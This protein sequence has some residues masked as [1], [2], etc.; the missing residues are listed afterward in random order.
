MEDSLEKEDEEQEEEEGNTLNLH[1]TS[2]GLEL[3]VL[4]FVLSR[5][6]ISLINQY[7]LD[8]HSIKTP[9][10]H[11]STNV[12]TAVVFPKSYEETTTLLA[13]A[14]S[15]VS[16]VPSAYSIQ[17]PSTPSTQKPQV[18]KPEPLAPN[19][20]FYT[21]CPGRTLSTLLTPVCKDPQKIPA[22]RFAETP[23]VC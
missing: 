15:P 13:L 22:F 3:F 9:S 16:T 21:T 5:P 18:D 1:N 11:S 7:L 17:Y 23:D 2:F 10:F 6:A 20:P 8:F 14:W 4:S 12:V 19:N